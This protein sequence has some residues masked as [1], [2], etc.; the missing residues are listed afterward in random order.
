MTSVT[1]IIVAALAGCGGGFFFF[2]S[3]RD[4]IDPARMPWMAFAQAFTG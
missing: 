1:T 4:M 3:W 2:T